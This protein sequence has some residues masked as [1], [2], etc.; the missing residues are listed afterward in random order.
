MNTARTGNGTR[1]T[2]KPRT[3]TTTTATAPRKRARSA[4]DFSIS[5]EQ[6]QRMIQEAAY[7]RAEQRGFTPGDAMA[8][9]LAAE[10]E[11]NALLEK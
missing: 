7:Y 5:A 9:W 6:R 10:A 3:T 2:S 8:D 1:R 4:A 11:V